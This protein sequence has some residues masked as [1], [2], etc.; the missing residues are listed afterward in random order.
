[1]KLIGLSGLAG[2]G[3]DTIAD[4]L[5][6]EYGFV[7]ISLSDVLKRVVRDVYGFTDNQLWGPSEARN[8]PDRRYPRKCKQCWGGGSVQLGNGGYENPTEDC[9]SCDGKGTV[10]L[11]A[12]H[13]LQTLGTEWGRNLCFPQTRTDYLLRQV[14]TLAANP[15]LTYN[16]KH[17]L[18]GKKTDSE[19]TLESIAGVVVPD[20]RFKNEIAE[21]RAS[22]LSP[23][24]VRVVRP[25]A[26]LVGAAGQ[27]ISEKEQTEI[28]DSD[29]D[30][31]IQ[32]D[33]TLGHLRG[34]VIAMMEQ[35]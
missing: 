24:L 9:P 5:V 34:A 15:Y 30:F 10:Y 6:E 2:S 26:G 8:E 1:M 21:F 13:A 18:R 19:E 22:A 17:G 3:K 32:N 20:L 29:F 7:K 4:F 31:I 14:E 28:P 12:R 35:A 16:Q 25:E 27:H 11:T 23:A 33:K